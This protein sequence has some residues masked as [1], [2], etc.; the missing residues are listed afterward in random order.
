MKITRI[1]GREIYDS[2]GLPT[3]ECELFLENGESVLSRVPSGLSTGVYEAVE[4]RDGGKRLLGKGVR[5]AIENIETLIAPAL[6]GHEPLG[7]EMDLKL[8][9]LDGTTDKSRLGSNTLLAVS[10]AIYK[11]EALSEKL[12]LYE[13]IA[14]YMGSDSVSLPY[15]LLNI[16]NGGMHANN[17]LRIQEF[18][19]VSIGAPTF[20]AAFEA[21][22][23]VYH[24]LKA[25]LIKKNKSTALGDEGGFAAGFESDIQAL[26]FLL[27]AIAAASINNSVGCIIA[28]DIAA[29]QYYNATTQLYS[30]QN[31][32]LTS[33]EL[34]DYYKK[35]VDTY[36]IYSIEDGLSEDDWSGWI[37]MTKALENKIQIVGDD[38][39]VTN[40]YR[41]AQGSIDHAATSV[42]IKPNQIG[43]VTETLQ[44][45]KLCKTTNLNTII[46]HR[47]GET[48]DTF[49]ADLAVG[50]S[51]GQ[52]KA[53][54]CTRAAKYN[55]LLSI[56]DALAFS[57]LDS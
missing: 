3:V 12:E 13:L 34:I 45:L 38:L 23:L 27:E 40:P 51:A 42:I 47:S 37:A 36:P 44:A 26:D 22:A 4:L 33:N 30:W 8:L 41:I 16:I 25:L 35:L 11:A 57:L 24:E 48:E 43:T 55:R 6:I 20:R 21:A 5:K 9:E 2:R 28:L 1:I 18:M 52:I 39:F 49:I 29:S 31:Q 46:S 32:E 10:M 7:M 54:S 56:E 53:G 19:I 17:K 15:P 50:A 14:Y